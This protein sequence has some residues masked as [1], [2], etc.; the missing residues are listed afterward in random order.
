MR[1]LTSRYTG[2][3]VEIDESTLDPLAGQRKP[4]AC[5]AAWTGGGISTARLDTLRRSTLPAARAGSA[6]RGLAHHYWV[7]F[8]R[9]ATGITSLLST[10]QK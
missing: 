9:L 10:V 6:V 8:V 5:S 2:L 3:E 1:L 7:A 4:E